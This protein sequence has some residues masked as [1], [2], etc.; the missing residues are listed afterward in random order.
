MI[1]YHARFVNQCYSSPNRRAY[2]DLRHAGEPM[3]CAAKNI[4]Y[5]TVKLHVAD[6]FEGPFVPKAITR[7]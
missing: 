3:R 2:H 5:W 4:G 7:Q 1:L 6:Q